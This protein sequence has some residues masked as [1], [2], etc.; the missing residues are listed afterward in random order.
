MN[1]KSKLPLEG[2]AEIPS[3][4]SSPLGLGSHPHHGHRRNHFQGIAWRF[5]NDRTADGKARN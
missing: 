4:S 1:T 2:H 5:H 3:R